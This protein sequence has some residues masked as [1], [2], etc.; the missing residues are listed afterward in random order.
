MI[1]SVGVGVGVSVG[2][3]VAVEKGFQA[4][5]AKLREQGYDLHSLAII[6]K[7]D[8]SGIYFRE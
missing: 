7:A 5:G 6:E 3:G 1:A 4:G 2:V 8:E